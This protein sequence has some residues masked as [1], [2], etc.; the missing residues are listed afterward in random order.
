MND[1]L[2]IRFIDGKTTPE[3]TELVL[4]ELSRDGDAAKEW[5]QMVQGARLADTKPAQEVFSDEFIA[6]T[7][8]TKTVQSSKRKRVVSLPWIISGITAV[9]ASVAIVVTLM[10]KD[11]QGNLP[12]GDIMA[13]RVDSTEDLVIEDTIIES[14]GADIK[15]IV[16]ERMAETIINNPIPAVEDEILELS[17]PRIFKGGA[18][19]T[20]SIAEAPFFEMVRPSKSPYKVKV[21]NIDKEFVFE[22]KI[23]DAASVRLLISDKEGNVL[24]DMEALEEGHCGIVAVELA[25]KGILDWTV[26]AVFMDGSK[27]RKSGKIELVSVN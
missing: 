6:K 27:A 26:H 1:D 4:S 9:A 11:G 14:D 24:I 8:A 16:Q 2:L 5:I 20:A 21:K 12:S 22:W 7:L 10:V 19:A 13:G 18:D 25:D 15:N 17:E 3:E 23:E